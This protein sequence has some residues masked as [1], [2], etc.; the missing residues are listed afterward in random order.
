MARSQTSQVI[1]I[2]A[3][4]MCSDASGDSL[5]ILYQPA[6]RQKCRFRIEHQCHL[7][8]D[9]SIKERISDSAQ[10]LNVMNN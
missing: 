3:R 6:L 7:K 4:D 10:Q 8:H 1:A 2:S 9:K 5:L